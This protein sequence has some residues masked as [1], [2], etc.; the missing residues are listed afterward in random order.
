MLCPLGHRHVRIL[1]Q[2]VQIADHRRKRSPDIMGQIHDQLIFAPFFL[3]RLRLLFLQL[4]LYRIQLTFEGQHFHRQTDLP[5]VLRQQR[6]YPL[7]DLLEISCH[8]PE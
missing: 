8:P 1:L 2:Q 5:P 6:V 7:I 4:P 3:S